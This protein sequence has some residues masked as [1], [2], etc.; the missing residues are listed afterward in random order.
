MILGGGVGGQFVHSA[1]KNVFQFN[2]V[3][4]T[5]RISLVLGLMTLS[6]TENSTSEYILQIAVSTV[7]LEYV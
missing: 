2:Y 4:Y 5:M 6:E 3:Q 7:L 1:I